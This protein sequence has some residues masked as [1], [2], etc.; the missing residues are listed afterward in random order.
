LADIVER[1]RKRIRE[2]GPLPF[3]DYME[4]VLLVY[5][6]SS[7]NPIGRTGDYYTSADLDPVF[8]QLLAKQFLQWSQQSDRFSIIELGAGKGLL[9][10]DILSTH[11]FEYMILERSP[12]MRARQREL[13]RDYSV[14]WIDEIPQGI[15][16]CIFSNEFFVARPPF[17]CSSR[18]SQ[19][20][21]RWRGLQRD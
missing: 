6:G 2:Q 21:L 3:R 16:G 4:E 17:D 11:E 19:G 1:L 18:S 10:R 8:G 15:T 7:E 5:Y 20:D 13:L 9:A 14:T 12:M